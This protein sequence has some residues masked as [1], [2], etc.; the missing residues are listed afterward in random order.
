M[1]RAL[2]SFLQVFS[3]ALFFL[4][5][6]QPSVALPFVL[7]DKAAVK[8]VIS[9]FRAEMAGLIAQAGGE[10]RVTLLRA[11]QLSDSMINALTAAYADS[12]TLTIGQLN[13]QQKRAFSQTGQLI[14]QIENAVKD[15]TNRA[16]QE[17]ADTNAIIADVASW[18]K[19]PIVTRYSPG[20]IAPRALGSE[21]RVSVAGLRLHGAKVKPPVLRIGSTEYKPDDHTDVSIGFSVPR[22]AFP[23][24]QNTPSLQSIT[25]VLYHDVSGLMPWNWSDVEEI[26]FRLLITVLPETLGT[27]T[28]MT[29]VS[30]QG[31]DE[32][33]L[34]TSRVL[35]AFGEGGTFTDHD[36]YVPKEGYK[37]DINSAE[38]HET[39]HT[40]HK[41]NDTSP[42][43]NIGRMEYH[44]GMK[45][46]RMICPQARS[47]VGCKECGGRTEGYMTVN[48]VKPNFEEKTE[49]TQPQ[50]ITWNKDIP[51]AL[52]EKAKRQLIELTL[53]DAITTVS[54]ATVAKT[55]QFVKIDPDLQNQVVILRPVR[56]WTAR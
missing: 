34:L 14:D 15:P 8:D 42:G 7:D 39:A 9:H 46:D 5:Y 17:F 22:T 1:L 54:A 20:F 56:D 27:Y 13:E 29:V 3:A 43:T 30:K 53:F 16:L 51:I 32:K 52:T 47:T 38:L 36:C 41:D 18:S 55:V 25:L 11:F 2:R 21:V 31:D 45:T 6:S 28:V 12:L 23:T 50:S 44:E 37:F 26:P 49:K 40:A 48:M 33:V 24:N 10:A 35:K 19:R 4:S